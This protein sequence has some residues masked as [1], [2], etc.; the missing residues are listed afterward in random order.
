MLPDNRQAQYRLLSWTWCMWKCLWYQ[1]CVYVSFHEATLF[2]RAFRDSMA[3]KNDV[4]RTIQK[5]IWTSVSNGIPSATMDC[6]VKI[7]YATDY[8]K[9]FF[10]R[11][12]YWLNNYCHVIMGV[13]VSKITS[14][15]IVYSTIHSGA[16]QRNCQRSGSLVFVRGIHRWPVNSPNKWPVTQKIFP[17]D[18]VIMVDGLSGICDIG[19]VLKIT[20]DICGSF[21]SIMLSLSQRDIFWSR[22]QRQINGERQ[23][24]RIYFCWLDT[25]EMG[26]IW[27]LSST[28]W[29]QPF[30]VPK[31]VVIHLR[32]I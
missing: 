23:V 13:M 3:L 6:L 16:D 9:D 20:D 8:G 1:W 25:T 4:W 17:F 7:F 11:K 31:T 22:Y 2:D 30:V 32:L 18:Y 21:W 10:G 24:Q 27:L 29:E 28:H 5:C 26:F 15:A 19:G 12:W 14:F